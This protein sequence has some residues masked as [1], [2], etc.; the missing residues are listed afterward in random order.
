MIRRIVVSRLRR[1]GDVILTTPVLDALGDAFPD[2]SLEYLT[3]EAYAPVLERHPRVD[4]ILTIP[5]GAGVRDTLR[6][7]RALRRPRVDWFFDL[8]AGPRSAV[9][10]RL[11]SPKHSVGTT[12][13]VRSRVFTHRR[14]DPGGSQIALHLDKLV[15]LLGPTPPRPTRIHVTEAER[16][17]ARTRYGLDASRDEI[18]VHPGA[19]WPCRAWPLDRWPRLVSL[20]QAHRQGCRVHVVTPPGAEASAHDLVDRCDGDVA[21]LPVLGLR[22]LFSVLSWGRLFVGNDGGVLHAAVALSVPTVA[23]IGGENDPAVW[24]PY[25][26]LGP[27][28]AVQR[29][30]ARTVMGPRGQEVGLPDADPDEVMD[31]VRAVLP[32]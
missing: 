14:A 20:L 19:S 31:A 1:L 29:V 11:C 13:G 9:L 23:L 30:S 22:D 15:P 17:T 28:R 2:A 25:T 4:R 16:H 21:A 10:V 24:F 18:F 12:R 27:Y 3:E 32:P 7:V 5:T 8:F 26:Q 6:T